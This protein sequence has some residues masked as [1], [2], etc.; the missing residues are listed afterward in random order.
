M[1]RDNS[2][3]YAIEDLTR[4]MLAISRGSHTSQPTLGG[5]KPVLNPAAS[6][7]F[8]TPWTR[9]PSARSNN[10]LVS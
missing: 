2:Q 8:L 6:S 9:V 4:E 1:T 10:W 7:Q 3:V 5:L